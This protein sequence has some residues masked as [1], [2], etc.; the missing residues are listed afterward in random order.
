M[1]AKD[2]AEPALARLCETY[3]EPLL[4][5]LRRTGY[6]YH[7]AADH[8][9]GFFEQLLRRRFLENVGREKGKFRTFLI[10]SL[11]NYLRDQHER[12]S[13]AKRGGGQRIES[14]DETDANGAPIYQ[15]V[16]ACPTPDVEF[17]RAWAKLLIAN[18]LTQLECECGHAGKGALFAALRPCLQAEPGSASYQQVGQRLGMAEGAVKVAAHRLR[19]RL[20][21][22]LRGAVM[23]TIDDE[24]DWRE[25]L[26]YLISLFGR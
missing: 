5:Y 10:C 19:G 20:A 26:G 18:A 7:A 22:L 14:L 4:G 9:Q 25:E 24:Q 1:Q 21:V 17:D 8:L 11:K 2:N 6:D 15:T 13:A 12:E 16:D 3:R 23:Q